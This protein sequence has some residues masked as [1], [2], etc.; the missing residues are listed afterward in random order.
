MQGPVNRLYE[1]LWEILERDGEFAAVFK[2]GNIMKYT[3]REAAD[4]K[5][6][7]HADYPAIGIFPSTNSGFPTVVTS[8]AYIWDHAISI[9]IKTG[10]KDISNLAEIEWMISRIILSDM[11]ELMLDTWE[12]D[13]YII[14][15]NKKI[16]NNISIDKSN[17]GWN[18]L[19]RF[20]VKLGVSR[21]K[22]RGES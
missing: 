21:D 17:Y 7:Q 22:F 15:L 2:P 16:N 14:C 13:N 11:S 9:D 10:D 20:D 4:K 5:L 19:I 6:K 3:S 18:T 12:G 1:K 8:S